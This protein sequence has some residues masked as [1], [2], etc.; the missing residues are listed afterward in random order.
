MPT[1]FWSR[2]ESAA[3]GDRRQQ[4]D[5]RDRAGA[6][7]DDHGIDEAAHV[8]ARHPAPDHEEQAADRHGYTAR[9]RIT[10]RW[11]RDLGAEIAV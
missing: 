5:P 9:E 2:L 7:R 3:V 10:D 11:E 1:S 4:E 6:D 8:P